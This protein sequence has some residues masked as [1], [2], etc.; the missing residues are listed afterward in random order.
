MRPCFITLGMPEIRTTTLPNGLRIITDHVPS[1]DS[2]AL[3]VWVGVGTRHEEMVHNGVAHLV[4]HM[5]FKGTQKRNALEIAQVIENVGGNVNAYTSREVTSYHIHLLKQDMSLALDVLA[6]IVQNSNMPEE[7]LEKER[8][9]VIQE[10]GM[11]NDTPD[12]VVFDHYYETAYPNQTLGAPILGHA[13]IIG[14][15]PRDVL[16]GYVNKFYTPA[17]MVVSAAGNLDHD[18]FVTQVEEQFSSLPTDTDHDIASARYES[19]EY[20]LQKDLEQSHVILGFQS[21]GRLDDDYYAGQALSTLL[22]G[23]MSSRLF[24]EIREK[25]GLVYSIFSFFSGYMDDGQFGIYAGTGPNDLP[26]LIPV[27]CEEIQKVSGSITQE[28]LTRAKA[29][30][31]SSMLMGRESMMTRADQQAK[32]MLFRNKTVDMQEIIAKIDALDTSD[33]DRVAKRIFTS[34]PTLVG[35]GPLG[36]LED[37]TRISQR[38]AA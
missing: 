10:I 28:E 34:K 15:M 8:H 21:F 33:I 14:K 17:R 7:E 18:E 35:I 31:K 29:Q 16:M 4:E 13:D 9:V 24:Q 1:V 32:Y 3:G 6:D 23:G 12:D 38:L 36:Q 30:L 26:E 20:R 27:V 2:I 19:G 25:R 22:G 11:C 5:L 37:Y